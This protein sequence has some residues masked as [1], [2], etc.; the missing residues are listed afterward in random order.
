MELIGKQNCMKNRTVYDENY[1]PCGY[2]HAGLR[3]ISEHLDPDEITRV[4]GMEPTRVL[5]AGEPCLLKSPELSKDSGWF[6]S[7]EGVLESL[8][9]R[10]H[11]DW[12]LE[13]FA[14]KKKEIKNFQDLGYRVD[15]SVMWE[16]KHGHDGPTLSPENLIG[17]GL[18][19][20]EVW[21]DVY[22]NYEE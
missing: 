9:S 20:I 17:F 21:F 22:F 18:L 19:D 14:S 10:D 15:V 1:S 12:I 2:T 4:F 3:V 8:D 11:L 13:R 6:I 16:S 5:R 7:T